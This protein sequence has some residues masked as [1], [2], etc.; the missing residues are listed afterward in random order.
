MRFLLVLLLFFHSP[1][2][3]E[4]PLSNPYGLTLGFQPTIGKR[5]DGVY[6][7]AEQDVNTPERKR[8]GS[9]PE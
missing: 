5:L 9:I 4:D 7:W 8:G 2:S 3:A 6:R 1:L